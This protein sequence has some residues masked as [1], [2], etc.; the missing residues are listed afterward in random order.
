M[1]SIYVTRLPFV[2]GY[3]QQRTFIKR[4]LASALNYS[5]YTRSQRAV[6]AGTDIVGC[7]QDPG[8]DVGEAIPVSGRPP[9]DAK[10]TDEM[11]V[12]RYM[13]RFRVFLAH[14]RVDHLTLAFAGVN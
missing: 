13:V 4:G 8:N 2:V 1:K 11:L 9:Q 10:W 14:H 3:D 7:E 6:R 5:G 12:G